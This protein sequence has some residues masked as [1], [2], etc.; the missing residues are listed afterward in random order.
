MN[1]QN[2][3]KELPIPATNI[4]GIVHTAFKR[5]DSGQFFTMKITQVNGED[6]TYLMKFHKFWSD[7]KDNDSFMATHHGEQCV[8]NLINGYLVSG[9]IT[10]EDLHTKVE[11][12]QVTMI[13]THTKGDIIEFNYIND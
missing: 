1:L 8:E 7:Q 4:C 10:V 9:Y 5:Q 12:R 6:P 13:T 11:I 2:A 3:I